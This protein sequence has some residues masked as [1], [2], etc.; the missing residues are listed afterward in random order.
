M[1]SAMKL[2]VW[3]IAAAVTVAIAL[4]VTAVAGDLRA[5]L[6]ELN[7]QICRAQLDGDFD[8]LMSFYADDAVVLPNYGKKLEGKKAIREKMEADREAGLVFESFTARIDE[9][10]ECEGMVYEIGTF[11]LS[12]SL[13]DIARPIGEK[14]KYMTVWRRGKRGTLKILYEIWNTDIE[15]G[16]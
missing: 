4:A 3:G 10:W 11:A 15:P 7:A 5:E 2:A 14:G 6:E 8:A 12:L 9:A 13:P 1:P 16:K